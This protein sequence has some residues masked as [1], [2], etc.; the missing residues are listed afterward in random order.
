M[1]LQLI[2]KRI[3]DHSDEFGDFAKQKL[4]EEAAAKH[5]EANRVWVSLHIVEDV[6][7]LNL[8]IRDNGLGFVP[9][10]V[11]T[12]GLGLNQ[13]KERVSA[14]GGT[15]RLESQPGT[16]TTVIAQLPISGQTKEADR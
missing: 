11:T 7:M 9:D 5:A 14:V 6:K 4:L 8:S 2:A 16:G 10:K 12:N 15:L 1:H 13:M 3:F